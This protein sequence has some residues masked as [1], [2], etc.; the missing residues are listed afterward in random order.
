[1][2]E[3]KKEFPWIQLIATIGTI[4]AA[5]IGITPYLL[6]LNTSSQTPTIVIL[7]LPPAV[8]TPAPATTPPVTPVET[9]PVV[10]QT[11]VVTTVPT[12]GPP[13]TETPANVTA[14]PTGVTNVTTTIPPTTVTIVTTTI[15][16]TTQPIPSITIA[17]NASTL[18]RGD[19]LF[20]SGTTDAAVPQVSI[21]VNS[22]TFQ[23]GAVLT[24]VLSGGR[25]EFAINTSAFAPGDYTIYAAVPGTPAVASAPFVVT[26]S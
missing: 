2:A 7:T 20:A 4:A 11:T 25:F 12:T 9:T 23:S 10:T 8:T 6:K 24:N 3:D 19:L 16:P 13:P 26:A 21:S 17:L 18:V 15:P 14:T 5:L 1:M 22:T